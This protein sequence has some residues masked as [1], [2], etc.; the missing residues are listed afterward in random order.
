MTASVGKWKQAAA[1][2]V[3]ALLASGAFWWISS[4]KGNRI[5]VPSYQVLRVIDGD[6]FVTKE[7]QYIRVAATEAPELDRCG[8]GEAKEA[9]EKLIMKKPV[10]LKVTY[11]DPYQRLVS[12]VYVNGKFVNKE[13]LVRGYSYYARGTEGFS[14]ELR[15]AGEVAREKKLGLFSDSCTQLTNKQKPSCNIKGNTRNGDIY[16]V[17]DCGVYDNVEVQLY[18]GDRWFCTEAEAKRAGFRKP[19]QCK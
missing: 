14:D 18:L 10:Y 5:P 2:G 12:L 19:E 6:T 15:Q 7:G 1:V 13:M 17:P 9:L 16:Y 4:G 8:G 11:R 3:T